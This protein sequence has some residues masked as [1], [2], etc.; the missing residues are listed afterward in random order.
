MRSIWGARKN[1]IKEAFMFGNCLVSS[2][3]HVR[4][5][6]RMNVYVFGLARVLFMYNLG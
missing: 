3:A 1:K 4:E 6:G 2:H 5:I